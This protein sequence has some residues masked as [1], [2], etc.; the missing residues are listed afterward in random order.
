MC[1]LVKNLSL[2]LAMWMCSSNPT[3][4]LWGVSETVYT[5]WLRLAP[6]ERPPLGAQ[7][8]PDLLNCEWNANELQNRQTQ[9]EEY[10]VLQRQRKF[11]R[12]CS[13]V[14]EA[15]QFASFQT[16][17]V[18]Y[19]NLL[20]EKQPNPTPPTGIHLPKRTQRKC[21][22]N[23]LKSTREIYLVFD[24]TCVF[25]CFMRLSYLNSMALF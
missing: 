10:E 12:N 14:F 5:N 16:E 3:Q 25:V 11:S 18:V 8:A 1:E 15:L 2:L 13:Q 19:E 7:L 23:Q 20:Q 9:G 24:V 21:Q 6:I 17:Y 22:S 4:I